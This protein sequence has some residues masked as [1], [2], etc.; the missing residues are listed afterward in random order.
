MWVTQMVNRI[1]LDVEQGG[2]IYV[3]AAPNF[4]EGRVCGF[5]VNDGA[6]YSWW[7]GIGS[8]VDFF[9]PWAVSW[10]RA[11]QDI[12]LD[13]G[14][15][16][17]K[18][19]FGES[20]IARSG[21]GYADLSTYDGV[22]SHQAYSEAYY[23]DFLRYGVAT[24]GREFVTM[25]RAWDVSYDLPARFYARPEHAPVVWMG[26][27]HR[28]WTGVV[29]VLDHALRSAEAG[30]VV[31][32]SDVGGYLDRRDGSLLDVIPYDGEVFGRWIALSGMMP[33]FQLHGRANLEPWN[34]EDA[35]QI[36]PVYRYWAT[37]H[38]EMVPFW[39]SLAEEAY[40][41][42]ATMMRPVLEGPSGWGDDYR[43][44]VGDALLVAPIFEAESETRPVGVR[45]VE[46]PPLPEGDHWH[47]WYEPAE[48]HEGGVTLVDYAGAAAFGR[49]PIFVKSGAIVPLR[50]RNAITGFGFEGENVFTVLAWESA[51]ASSFTVH[52]EDDETTTLSFESGVFTLSRVVEPTMLRL[53]PRGA[54][55]GVTIGGAPA[56]EQADRA[57]LAAANAGY[58]IE[59]GVVWVKL[60]ASEV[61]VAVALVAE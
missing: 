57:T 40:A 17:W 28:D 31:I 34:V 29:D 44:L 50:P 10:W 51:V 33:F 61:A 25:V 39:Y 2:D 27:N 56:E 30:Y 48:K 3:G 47:D 43:Y 13:A 22:K 32:G 41:G 55:T 15:D 14:I 19:D 45:S 24:R 4:Y 52:D 9:N 12:V 54:V 11:Q 49:V 36:L 60:P 42:R 59:G 58:T 18:L 7:K 35:E 37:L 1:G 21:S 20:Y 46:L 26:D 53:V 8:A 6:E 5:F 23:A 38:S 16:G